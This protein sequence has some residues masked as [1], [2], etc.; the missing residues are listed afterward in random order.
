MFHNVAAIGACEQESASAI[1]LA[2]PPTAVAA[3][4]T[5]TLMGKSK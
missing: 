2:H 1:H 4:K 5:W 3:I